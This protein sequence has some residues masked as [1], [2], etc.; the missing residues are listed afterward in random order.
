MEEEKNTSKA[1]KYIDIYMYTQ[2]NMESRLSCSWGGSAT[3][4]R[5]QTGEGRENEG[6][7]KGTW[8]AKKKYASRLEENGGAV[9]LRAAAF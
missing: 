4:N 6:E 7:E 1:K 2:W 3:W 8:P 9:N 5:I